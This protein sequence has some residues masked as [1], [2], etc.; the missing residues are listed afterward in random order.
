LGKHRLIA[1]PD[2]PP[3][4]IDAIEVDL[5]LTRKG[6]STLWYTVFGSL[7]ALVVPREASERRVDELWKTTCFE[8]FVRNPSSSGYL[9]LNFSP[10]REWAAYHFDGYRRG[11]RPAELGHPP[12]ISSSRIGWFELHVTLPFDLHCDTRLL[13]QLSAVLEEN[14]G[15]KSYWA[16]AHPPGDPDFHQPDCFALELP[17]AGRI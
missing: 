2:F 13:L 5:D 12:V 7:D 11:M 16:L 9:E 10:S 4:A 3:I 1:H 8:M 6:V 14:E 17:P 15:T